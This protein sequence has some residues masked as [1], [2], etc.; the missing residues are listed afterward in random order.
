MS[1]LVQVAPT[2][3]HG[4]S[5]ASKTLWRNFGPTEM[6]CINYTKVRESLT[7]CRKLCTAAKCLD[8]RYC[9][10]ILILPLSLLFPSPSPPLLSSLSLSL[11]PSLS[12]LPPSSSHFPDYVVLEDLTL[13]FQY[14]CVL[15][16]K[17]GTRQHGDDITE[18]KRKLQ[19]E[20][21]AKSTSQT[22]GVRICGMQVKREGEGEGR[23]GGEKGP[24]YKAIMHSALV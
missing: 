22:L 23:G 15:D 1:S 13:K 18:E 2:R 21:C 19:A 4:V 10:L 9:G 24:G 6:A 16:L 17:V 5:S 12:P 3:T 8:V 20:K 7:L 11:P 14:P